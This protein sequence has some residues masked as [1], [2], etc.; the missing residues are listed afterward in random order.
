MAHNSAGPKEDILAQKD[1]KF[2]ILCE[3]ETYL[4]EMKAVCDALFLD[5]SS[6]SKYTKIELLH[7]M[8]EGRTRMKNQVSN[9]A[10]AKQFYT[11]IKPS[12]AIKKTR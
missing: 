11:Y 9:I 5:G 2:G 8:E 1:K 12:V 3:N 10:F 7:N 6:K 4:E